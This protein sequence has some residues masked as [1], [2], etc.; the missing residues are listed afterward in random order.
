MKGSRILL[1][2]TLLLINPLL[3][4]QT[5][6]IEGSGTG[7]DG[8]ELRFFIQSDPVSKREKP[9][10]RLTC[11]DSGFF[12]CEIPVEGNGTIYIKSG[13]FSMPLHVTQ[14]SY[15]KIR[16]PDFVPRPQI[17]RAHV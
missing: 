3:K 1:P 17:G 2:L 7:Y 9:V 12:R 14:G 6:A 8:V 16:M 5:V 4:C 10:L 13:I 15:Y 11:N